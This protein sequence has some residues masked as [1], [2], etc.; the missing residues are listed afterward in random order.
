MTHEIASSHSKTATFVTA[1]KV[2]YISLIF[3]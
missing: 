1:K 3:K 2:W